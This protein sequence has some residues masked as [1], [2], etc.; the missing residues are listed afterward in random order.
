MD[1]QNKNLIL[2]TVLSCVVLVVWLYIFPPSSQV[3]NF[4]NNDNGIENTLNSGSNLE[5]VSTPTIEISKEESRELALEKSERITIETKRLRGSISLNGGRIDDLQ[6][7]DYNVRLNDESEKVTLL[8][9]AGAPNAYFTMY[10][11]APAGSLNFDEVPG[12]STKWNVDGNSILT[13]STPISLTWDNKAG[14]TFRRDISIDKDYLFSITQ[15]VE[16]NSSKIVRMR[17][18]GIIA[19]KGE[20][21]MR[22]FFIL[23]EGI[24][25]F[26]DGELDELD[27]SD[28]EDF[29]FSVNERASVEEKNVKTSGWIGFTDH[30]WMTTLAPR[31][32]AS[33]QTAAKYSAER[34][35]YQTEFRYPVVDI[36]PATSYSVETNLFAGAKEWAAINSYE[37]SHNIEKFVDS[38]DWGWFFFLTKPIFRVLFWLNSIIGNMGWSIVGLTLIIKTI[39]FPLAYKSHVSMARMK[40]LQ[41]EMEKIKERAGDDRASLQKEMMKLYK[42]KKVNPAAGCLPILLQI[43][44]FFSLYKVIFVTLALRHEPWFGWI[45]DLSAPDPTSWLNLFGLLPW[46]TPDPF[47][48]FALLSIGVFPILMGVTMWLQQKLN[49]APTDATQ[50]MIFAWMPWIFMFMLGSFASGLVIYWVANNTITFIQQYTIMRTQGVKPDVLGNIFANL[51]FVKK[52]EN[53]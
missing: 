18:Y 40:E 44:I 14:L 19:R 27:Y 43:P 45:K 38:I 5:G 36:Q 29:E 33:F 16:N 13:E 50:A 23:H 30:Y 28:L 17:P 39:L 41:P 25:R 42:E 7:L 53:K 26:Q 11:W 46:G 47:S 1:D 21:D 3:E 34:D 4:S 6:L 15:T 37:K 9:P 35:T 8:S 10:G 52:K 24:V 12:A 31:Q 49:P 22:G 20:P 48:I 2:A 51:K 32:G